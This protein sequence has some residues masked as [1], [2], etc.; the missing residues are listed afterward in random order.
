VL[1]V[2][3]GAHASLTRHDLSAGPVVAMLGVITVL[4]IVT[5]LAV[6][7]LMYLRDRR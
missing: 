6:A 7:Y 2:P 3:D 5:V 1:A 4:A